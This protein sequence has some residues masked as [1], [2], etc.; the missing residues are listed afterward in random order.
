LPGDVQS[1]RFLVDVGAVEVDNAG[2]IGLRQGM[3]VAHQL[4][5]ETLG[6]VGVID[7]LKIA[8]VEITA[9][10]PRIAQQ[11]AAAAK[12]QTVKTTEN[13]NNEGAEAQ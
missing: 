8:L 2:A 5:G 12:T 13:G 11:P 6:V 10:A 4:L 3:R 7:V 9:D 1:G